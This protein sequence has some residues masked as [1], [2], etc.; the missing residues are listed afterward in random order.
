MEKKYTSLIPEITPESLYLSRRKFIRLAS[1]FG[2]AYA[3]AACGV[4]KQ[5]ENSAT[6]TS[7]P[8]LAPTATSGPLVDTPTSY[9]AITNFNNYY[10][11]S[12]DKNDVAKVAAGF[13]TS[14][15]P[16]EI[17]GLVDK[18]QTLDASELIARYPAEERIYRMRCVEGWS[19]VIPWGGF[20]L[21]KL[22]DDIGVR[23]EAKFVKFTTLYAPDKMPG[24]ETDF[25]WPYVEG[26]RLDEARHD[27]T[28]LASNI[29]GKPMLP[30]N[31]APLRLVVPWKYGFKSI[32]AIVKIELVVD[33]PVSLW[34]NAAPQEYGFYSNVNPNVPHPR[35]SQDS[36]RRIG[37]SKRRPTLMFNGYED[38][39]AYL[40]EGMDL[41]ANY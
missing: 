9:E 13:S 33:Q 39:V 26:L 25:V 23:A 32:K 14:P 12:F 21:Y 8:N 11:F 17:S 41:R 4:T 38:E 31:G 3:L 5:P 1:L 2:T 10:E 20:P 7:A 15:W 24:Q 22:L 18:P 27:L 36:E 19:M 30:Q 16:I 35:W 37:E 28:L 29:Y 34:T 40:Y 6:S